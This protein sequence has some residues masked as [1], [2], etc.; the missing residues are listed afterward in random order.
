MSS[1]GTTFEADLRREV[2]SRLA[3]ADGVYYLG[4]LGDE[5]IHDWGRVHDEF[6]EFVIIDRAGEQ[7]TLVVAADD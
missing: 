7:L 5:A 1:S 2:F 6:H 4:E 3:A